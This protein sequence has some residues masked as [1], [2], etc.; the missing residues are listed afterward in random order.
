M[1]LIKSGFFLSLKRSPRKIKATLIFIT[2]SMAIAAML[3]P[4]TALPHINNRLLYHLWE[5]GHFVVFFLGCAIFYTINPRF[6]HLDGARQVVYLLCIAV[7]CALFLEGLQ[8][9]LSGKAIEFSDIIGDISGVLLFL[10]FRPLLIGKRIIY[11]HSLT[12][13][14]VGFVLWP[15][16]CSLLDEGLIRYQFPMLADFETPYEASRFEGSTAR[17]SISTEHAFQGRHSLKFFLTSGPWSGMTLEHS[18]A[19]WRNYEQLHFAVFNPNLVPINFSVRIQ[20]DIHD[21]GDKPYSDLYSQTLS[22]PPDVWTQ[23]KIPLDT[24]KNAPLG[25]R[26]DLEHISGLGFFVEEKKPLVLYLDTIRLEK[27]KDRQ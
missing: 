12:L 2:L 10:S 9:F 14:L 16:C 19:D 25:R 18:P 17:A 3:L 13:L 23:V 20:D 8:S 7:T 1:N 6:S 21:Q 11:L 24:V 27:I 5:I 4:A 26:M 15:V 22:L